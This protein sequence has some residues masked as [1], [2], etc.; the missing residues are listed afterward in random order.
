MRLIPSRKP[1]FLSCLALIL[2]LFTISILGLVPSPSFSAGQKRIIKVGVRPAIPPRCYLS[3][4]EGKIVLKGVYIDLFNQISRSL[5]NAEFEFVR[6]QD[7]ETMNRLVTE[8]SVDMVGL[9]IMPGPNE[10]KGEFRYIQVDLYITARIFIQKSVKDVACTLDLKHKHVA[11]VGGTQSQHLVDEVAAENIYPAPSPLDALR[12]VNSGIVDAFI[13]PSE[14]IARYLIMTEGFTNVRP[15]G[16][17]LKQARLAIGLR[18]DDPTL[19]REIKD[20]VDRANNGGDLSRIIDQWEH[21]VYEQNFFATHRTH[22]F[23]AIGGA[24]CLFIGVL[25]WNRMLNHKVRKITQ[26]LSTSERAY[27][28]LIESSPDMIFVISA[29]GEVLHFNREAEFFIPGE[30]LKNNILPNIKEIISSRD[31][32]E[33]ELFIS[34]VFQKEKLTR[35]FLAKD[36]RGQHREIDLA[37]TR[38]PTRSGEMARACL[39]ARDVTQKNRIERDLVQAD[40]MAIIGQMAA[41]VA[42]EINNPI[43]IIRANID[44]ILDRNWF[45]PEAKEFLESSQRNTVRAGEYT[46]ELLAISRPKIPEKKPLNLSDL[47]QATLAVMGAPLKKVDITTR[48][49]GTP[50]V[51]LGD[52]NLIQQVLVNLMLN[53]AAAMEG[54]EHPEMIITC[55]VPKGTDMVRLRVEDRG[56]GIPKK[57]LTRVFDPFFTKGKKEGFGLG[58]FICRRIIENHQGIIY[59]ESELDQGTQ[60][61]VELPLETPTDFGNGMD[62]EA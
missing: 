10:P 53:G 46:R 49:R 22:I 20:A 7:I 26:D 13:A 17:A 21:I 34:R 12:M 47:I 4:E 43:G 23:I 9:S 15:V 59:V 28:N 51:V 39:F 62:N 56:V 55:C 57:D 33:L 37:A 18:A 8:G 44:L 31:R 1:L 11:I 30:P 32:D 54:R 52:W 45:T 19:Y 60:F 25:T 29:K 58:L 2:F 24:F 36:R 41:N 40:R 35:E 27:R 42:H 3:M 16:P 5:D 14:E 6:C 38:L 48:H 50:P 61:I